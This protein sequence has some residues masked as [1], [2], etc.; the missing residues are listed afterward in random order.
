[1]YKVKRFNKII[2]DKSFSKKN[3]EDVKKETKR[4]VSLVNKKYGKTMMI[5]RN[6]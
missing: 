5:L 2:E 6:S 1:M 4:L 3:K